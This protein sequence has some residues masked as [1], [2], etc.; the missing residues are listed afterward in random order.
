MNVTT[1]PRQKTKTFDVLKRKEEIGD[2]NG[3]RDVPQ[4]EPVILSFQAVVVP[5]KKGGE[6]LFYQCR[7]EREDTTTVYRLQGLMPPIKGGRLEKQEVR[8]GKIAHTSSDGKFRL[9]IVHPMQKP[10]TLLLKKKEN[11][12]RVS[13]WFKLRNKGT[14]GYLLGKCFVVTDLRGPLP[15]GDY[16]IILCEAQA[17]TP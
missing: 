12:I 13:G 7:E 3:N 10:K 1:K 17:K 15:R 11:G 5:V 14:N 4:K 6:E 2:V 8:I 16:E 9:V